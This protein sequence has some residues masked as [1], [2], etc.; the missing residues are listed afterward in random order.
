VILLTNSKLYIVSK[1]IDHPVACLDIEQIFSV[2]FFKDENE[3]GENLSGGLQDSEATVLKIVYYDKSKFVKEISRKKD[4]FEVA[5]KFIKIR[6]KKIKPKVKA[7]FEAR[8]IEE[9]QNSF[10]TFF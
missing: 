4:P 3:I 2:Q 5:S 8:M 7:E 6:F 9:K 1:L 10:A